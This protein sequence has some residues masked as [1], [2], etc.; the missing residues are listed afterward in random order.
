M[1]NTL[2]KCGKKKI[3]AIMTIIIIPVAPPR[4]FAQVFVTIQQ[5]SFITYSTL[6]GTAALRTAQSALL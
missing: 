5:V 4:K 1:V 6:T 2:H 3:K